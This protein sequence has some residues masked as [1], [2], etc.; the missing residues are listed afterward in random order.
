MSQHAMAEPGMGQRMAAQVH[1]PVYQGYQLLHI[2]FTVAPILTGIDKFAHVLVDWNMYLSPLATR[3][4]GLSA[5]AFMSIVGVIEIVAGL[6]VAMKPRIGGI[7]VGCWL[8]AI[9]INLL[10][11]ASF[12]DIALRDAGLALGAFALARLSVVEDHN[13]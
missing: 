5:Q 8:C 4:T 13:L 10:A 11:Q 2:A 9:I 6:I 3:V 1:D 7:I 12:F